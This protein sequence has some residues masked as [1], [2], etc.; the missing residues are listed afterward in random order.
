MRLWRD[1]AFDVVLTDVNMP[2][3]NGYQLARALR[4]RGCRVPLIGTTANAMRE[5]IERCLESGMN[6]CL[7]KPLDL[8]SLYGCL[9]PIQMEAR[10]CSLTES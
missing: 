8:H 4:E 9:K 2:G 1:G 6:T 5:E 10:E 7:V 3:M